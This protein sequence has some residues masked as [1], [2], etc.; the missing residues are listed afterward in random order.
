MKN[1]IEKWM[2]GQ[3]EINI[4]RYS[5]SFENQKIINYYINKNQASDKLKITCFYVKIYKVFKRKNV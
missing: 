3:I 1:M 2:K 4:E 5:N